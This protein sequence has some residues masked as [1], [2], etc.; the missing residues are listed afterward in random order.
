MTVNRLFL[1]KGTV[2]ELAK[3]TERAVGHGNFKM[4]LAGIQ[5]VEFALVPIYLGCPKPRIPDGVFFIQTQ[6]FLLPMRKI[7]RFI[8]IKPVVCSSFVGAIKIIFSV[9]RKKKRIGTVKETRKHKCTSFN[10]KTRA[11]KCPCC[12]FVI[13]VPKNG[14]EIRA[15][16]DFAGFRKYLSVRLVR[17]HSRLP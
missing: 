13:T 11:E 7:L 3:R 2:D 17:K 9:V 14:K 12:V 1:A 4:Y 10:T 16:S 15:F 5:H 6:S 8:H